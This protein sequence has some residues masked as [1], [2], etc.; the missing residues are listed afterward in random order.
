M[1]YARPAISPAARPIV[2]DSREGLV[3]FAHGAR[4]PRWAEPLQRLRDRVAQRAP[5]V[6]V[7]LAFLEH[8]A[9]DLAGGV[10]RTVAAGATRV[11]VI[12]LFLGQGGHVRRDLPDRVDAV[13]RQFPTVDV[14][15]AAATTPASSTRWR[16]I[17]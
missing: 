9:P 16:A 15:V 7:E 17:A 1:C 6:A 14:A 10:A 12:P 5:D 8:L 4:D 2:S 13:R 3:L 11:T